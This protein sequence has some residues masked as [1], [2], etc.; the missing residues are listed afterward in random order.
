MLHH[1][2][3]YVHNEAEE[4]VTNFDMTW[5]ALNSSAVNTKTYLELNTVGVAALLQKLNFLLNVLK[6][7]LRVFARVGH[8]LHCYN[9]II[10]NLPGKVHIAKTSMTNLL[11]EKYGKGE[12]LNQFKKI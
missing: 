11:K 5:P 12:I 7:F 3:V 6:F 4:F 1:F 2:I 9:V 10:V 8:F